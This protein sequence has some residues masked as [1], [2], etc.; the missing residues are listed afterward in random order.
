[1]NIAAEVFVGPFISA[2]VVGIISWTTIR[3]EAARTVQRINDKEAFDQGSAVLLA[4]T[5]KATAVALDRALEE[6]HEEYCRRF[7]RIEKRIGVTNGDGYLVSSA[8]CSELHRAMN[9]ANAALTA[10]VHAAVLN[11]QEAIRIGHADREAIKSRLTRVE[12][13]LEQFVKV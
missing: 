1:M 8:L 6:R 3:I 9:V 4:S 5:V 7:D 10:E 13:M 12:I 2:L 11:G